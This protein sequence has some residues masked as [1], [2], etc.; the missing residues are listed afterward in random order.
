M[1]TTLEEK[2]KSNLE[3]IGANAKVI[4]GSIKD[5]MIIKHAS[6]NA[7]KDLD[8]MKN[9]VDNV[10]YEYTNSLCDMTKTMLGYNAEVIDREVSKL[11][12]KF[13]KLC[14]NI[15]FYI[16]NKEVKINR[17]VALVV[18]ASVISVS[19]SLALNELIRRRRS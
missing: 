9:Y 6:L 7:T 17:N 1:M 10:A 18:T 4:R 15:T 12:K 13:V 5:G 8:H 14:D 19:A 3:P 2:L 16:G 11:D